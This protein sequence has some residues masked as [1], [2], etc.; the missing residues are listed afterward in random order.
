MEPFVGAGFAELASS[1]R[2]GAARPA[3]QRWGPFLVSDRCLA[4]SNVLGVLPRPHFPGQFT[5][6]SH[7][8][9]R[10]IPLHFLIM[11]AGALAVI[12]AAVLPLLAGC[13]RWQEDAMVDGIAFER[14][15]VDRAGRA[16][17]T[18][19][20]DT[21]IAGSP[22]HQG[23][24]HL[25]ANGVPALFQAAEEIVLPHVVIPVG[26]WVR[27]DSSGRITVCSFPQDQVI[28]GYRCRGSGGPK[29]VQVAF[30]ANGTLRQFFLV[31]PTVIDGFPCDTGLVR[32]SV[33][34]HDNGRLRSARLSQDVQRGNRIY[35]QG[36]R[37]T[38]DQNGH[39]V[40]PDPIVWMD[41]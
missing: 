5:R 12:S 7:R 36:T 6:E 16:A 32:G 34:L 18:L 11:K 33:E 40:E 35:R 1:A 20:Q 4:R 3:C 26:T 31:E 13:S 27:Q 28:Q 37:I 19:A 29:G 14:V 39:I 22:C 9:D 30:H 23:Y 17:G 8:R 24:V 2:M 25:H 41:L 10:Q 21:T 38:I 15:K